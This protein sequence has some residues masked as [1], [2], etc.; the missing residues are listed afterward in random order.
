LENNPEIGQV[1]EIIPI[2]VSSNPSSSDDTGVLIISGDMIRKLF[3]AIHYMSKKD[4]VS[5]IT[6]MYHQ[7]QFSRSRV[8]L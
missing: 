4:I 5:M 1:G 2:I 6:T 8:F 7:Q 3:K